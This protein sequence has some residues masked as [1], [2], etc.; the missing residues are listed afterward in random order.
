RLAESVV[1]T[2]IEIIQLP[3]PAALDGSAEA[4]DFE[5][6]VDVRNAVGVASFG[7]DEMAFTAAELLPRWSNME[8]EPK[9]LY[10]A[11][12][13]GRIVARGVYEYRT[14]GEALDTTWHEVL[15]HPEFTGRGVGRVLADAMEERAVAEGKAR[16]LVWAN[17]PAGPGERLES[18]TGFGSLPAGNREVRFLLARGFTLEQVERASR[19]P[20]PVPADELATRRHA[21]ETAAGADYR[22]LHWVGRTPERWREDI[23]HLLTRMSTDAPSAGLDEPEDPWTVER[24]LAYE[25]KAASSPRHELIAVVEHVP[26][27]T[28][29]GLTVL[30]VPP[31]L[32]RPVSQEDT[33]VLKEH[34]GHRLGML[35]KVANIL[36][37]E[38]AYPGHPAI[39]TFNAEEN[40]PMLDVN[41]SVGFTPM[42]YIGAWKKVLR[43]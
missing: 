41:E 22:E 17:S 37:L 30:S 2:D 5:S 36:N 32:E 35:L 23:A 39:T 40:R 28:L 27:G 15:V 19:L 31:E 9:I 10:V 42:A 33:I 34:R 11:R 20:L 13:D 38:E 18:P 7:T 12:I 43:D 26:T 3:I 29:A 16:I 1:M 6:T 24:L 25:D 21:A 4:R 14:G 8:H